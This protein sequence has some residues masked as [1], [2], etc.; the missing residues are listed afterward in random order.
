M[1]RFNLRI[2]GRLFAGFA[3]LC[4]VLALAVACTMVAIGQV[5]SAADRAVTLRAPAA[6]A[7][8][9]LAGDL[10][11]T[12]AELRGYLLTGDG[13]AKAERAAKWAEI[14]ALAV[15]L[16][17]MV[18]RFT[19]PENRRKWEDIKARLEG[20]RAAQ[21]KAE[22]IAFTP[23]AFPA[24]HVLLTE[25]APR[26]DVMF[27]KIT[28][29]INE[30]EHLE[31]TPERKRLLKS[32]A[33]T[34]GNFTAAMAHLRTYL[35]S[36]DMADKSKFAAPWESF[37][38]GLAGIAEQGAL[39]VPA[40]RT[41]FDAFNKAY[42]ELAPLPE[43]MFALR[44]S[45]QWN[46]PVY[47][48]TTE[49]IPQA[50]RLLEL[51]EGA[52]DESGKRAGGLKGSQQEMLAVENAEMR[53]DISRL[54]LI[55]WG[56]LVGG[57]VLGGLA[58]LFTA[59]SI[60]PP[61][62]A[63]TTSMTRLA[64]SDLSVDIPG[65]SRKDEIGDMA[66]AM[67][68]FKDN[69]IE[70]G[71]L[72]EERAASEA[73]ADEQ[74]R[75][76]MN[77]LANDFD[78]AVGEVIKTV[79]S[80]STELEAAARSLTRTADSTQELSATAAAASEETSA[81]VGSV[82]AATEQLSQSV[83]EI[84]RQVQEAS[85]IAADAVQQAGQTDAHMTRLSQAGNRIGE[86]VELISA[87]AAQ[88]NLLALN[89]TIEAARAGDSG[90]GFAVVASEVKELATQ[91]AQATKDIQ[92]HIT[93]VQSATVDSVAAINNIRATIG[94]ISEISSAIAAA[95]EEQGVATQEIAANIQVAAKG[96]TEVTTSIAS[97]NEGASETGTASSQVLSS[98]AL[99]SSD[100][101]RLKSEV[102]R[103]LT[104]VRAA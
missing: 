47:T 53:E 46:M 4:A 79:S 38:R 15:R 89:A 83:N 44:G 93:G 102:D 42:A 19:N 71:R 3:A 31:A 97:V 36:G 40:Q 2:S 74:R 32:M 104:T 13:A 30:E 100:S 56:L 84:S 73:R 90:R 27:A 94:R 45:A 69:M 33:D 78:S 86:V 7:G 24:S 63:M 68:V 101:H 65:S 22:A 11:A 12:L 9:E 39:L 62:R 67:Q 51:I 64:G 29:M 37:R 6:I 16:D 41:A 60:V 88:T 35:L 49:A 21:A 72:R 14:D 96:V 99:L 77:R 98:A 50:A 20:F 18:A 28:A 34:R 23:D 25:A 76:E 103:F 80:A 82:A 58:A 55:E 87:I 52:K 59:R 8:T 81:N 48:L 66:D 26:A 43:R 5:S 91:T 10:Y 85:R 75:M 61:L 1:F 92:A 54:T 95:V 57:L 17:G 70:A